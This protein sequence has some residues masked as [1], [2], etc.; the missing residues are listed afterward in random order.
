MAYS[1]T[2]NNLSTAI[3]MSYMVNIR[4]CKLT[5]NEMPEMEFIMKVR[6]S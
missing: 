6:L 2:L 4:T 5:G 3:K 1:V